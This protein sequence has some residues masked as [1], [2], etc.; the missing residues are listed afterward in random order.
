MADILLHPGF[1][2]TGTS[3]MQHLLWRNRELLAPH[4]Q[5]FQLRHLRAAAKLCMGYSRSQNPLML[6]DLV[7]ALDDTFEGLP[8]D[9]DRHLL[10][11]CEGLSGHLP[12]WPDVDSYAAAPVTA[13][14]I[15]GYLADRFPEHRVRLIYTTRDAEGWLW[16]AW[17]HHLIGQRL[18]EGWETFRDR[19]AG[20]A[21]LS[22]AAS[23]VGEALAP[24]S[25]ATLDL[26]A[27]T[28][29]PLGPGAALLDHLTLP[30]DVRAALK[31]VGH[32]NRGPDRALAEEL[33]RLNRSDMA[34][35]ALKTRKLALCE[36]DGVGGWARGNV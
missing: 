1:H 30:E 20:A 19:L 7:T 32:G 26:A 15:A 5:I 36:A 10:L 12:G 4:V 3:S 34:N 31:P 35:D 18:T 28:A 24:L 16:S 6:L 27:A 21:D 13:N 33:L 25:V 17:R 11:S 8:A 2:K 14:F 9:V 29:H 23:E 22:R